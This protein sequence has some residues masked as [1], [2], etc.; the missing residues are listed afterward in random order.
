M[1]LTPIKKQT[2][3]A[4]VALFAAGAV[5][6]AL[7]AAT[8]QADWLKAAMAAFAAGNLLGILGVKLKGF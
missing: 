3:W 2:F 5:A 8:Q 7:A 6:L 4:M 1:I